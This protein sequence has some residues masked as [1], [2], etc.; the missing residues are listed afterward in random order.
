MVKQSAF[1]CCPCFIAD[2]DVLSNL[3]RLPG[4]RKRVLTLLADDSIPSARSEIR[5]CGWLAQVDENGGS[6]FHYRP[7]SKGSQDM[8]ALVEEVLELFNDN[9]P[10][11]QTEMPR[12]AA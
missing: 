6:I 12:I 5:S 9:G 7:L 2:A 8:A 3:T 1:F 10:S 11:A 4:L